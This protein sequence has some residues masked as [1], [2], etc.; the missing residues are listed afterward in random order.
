MVRLID[1][2][3]VCPCGLK[4][5]SQYFGNEFSSTIGYLKKT[6]GLKVRTCEDMHGKHR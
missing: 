5:L 6:K 3:S 2:K 4:V 1:I